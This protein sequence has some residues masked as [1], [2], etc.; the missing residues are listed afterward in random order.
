[1]IVFVRQIILLYAEGQKATLMRP[2]LLGGGGE[3]ILFVGTECPLPVAVH[4]V[5]KA[6]PPGKQLPHLAVAQYGRL[7]CGDEAAAIL[8]LAL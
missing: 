1:M 5:N 4:E 3:L 6:V 2:A 7:L 8:E